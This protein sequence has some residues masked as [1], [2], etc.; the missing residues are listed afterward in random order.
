MA[1]PKHWIPS[2]PTFQNYYAIFTGTPVPGF[3]TSTAPAVFAGGLKN[4][5]IITLSCVTIALPLVVFAGF[6]FSRLRFPFK[7]YFFLGIFAVLLLPHLALLPALYDMF[8]SFGLIDTPLALILFD[9]S[10]SV[11]LGVWLM[12]SYFSTI[13]NE[14]IKAGRVDGCSWRGV[15]FKVVLPPAVPGIIAVTIIEFIVVWNEFI[16]ALV[17]TETMASKTFPVVL[18]EF[19]GIAGV[20]YGGMA[21]AAII[22]AIPAFIFALAFQKYIVKG[23]TMGAVKG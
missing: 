4:S 3:F 9:L 20:D 22:A 23:L 21:A 18:A 16:G 2:N 11:P 10:W 7:K 15:L 17:F 6:A 5:L 8:G 19:I 1:M 13:P 12:A 14:L